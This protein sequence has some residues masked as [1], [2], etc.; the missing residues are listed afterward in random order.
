[1]PPPKRSRDE[2]Q[3]QQQ[4]RLYLIFDDWD[5]GYTIRDIKLSPPATSRHVRRSRRRLVEYNHGSSSRRRRPEQQQ[6]LITLP[7]PSFRLEAPRRLPWLF[8]AIGTKIMAMHGVPNGVLP[9]IDIRPPREI[10]FGPWNGYANLPIYFP[11][12][13]HELFSLDTF[14]FRKL[15]LMKPPLSLSL[16]PPR[17]EKNTSNCCHGSWRDLPEPPFS[18][19]DVDSYGVHP[20]G[21][22]ILVSTAA[23]TYAFDTE[24][25]AAAPAWKQCASRPLPFTG[26]AHFVDD[27]NVFVGLSK[28]QQAN[29]FGRLCSAGLVNF[30]VNI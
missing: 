26:R 30:F 14:A 8:A 15:S 28:D 29:N 19:M 12:G 1:M 13:D 23:A 9:M 20:D 5:C 10:T 17:L 25:A 4:R 6:Q 21:R 22:T 3:E 24:A 2:R 11:I 7:P 18:R 27:L 16:C